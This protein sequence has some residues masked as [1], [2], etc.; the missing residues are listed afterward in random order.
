MSP[1][2]IFNIIFAF[3]SYRGFISNSH[4]RDLYLFLFVINAFASMYLIFNYLGLL[5]WDVMTQEEIDNSLEEL[6]NRGV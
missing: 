2:I 3:I 6:K 5:K 4:K 1:L